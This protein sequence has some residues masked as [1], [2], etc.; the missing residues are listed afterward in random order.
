[1]NYTKR[2]N[3]ILDEMAREKEAKDNLDYLN[4]MKEIN[5]EVL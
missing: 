3:E 2:R 1:M 4:A 5:L